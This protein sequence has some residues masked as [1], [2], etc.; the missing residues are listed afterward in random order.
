[1]IDYS[2]SLE[3]LHS[4]QRPDGGFSYQPGGQA[5]P[6]CTAW[7]IL[8]LSAC[9]GQDRSIHLGRDYL[10][11]LQSSDG[12]V[13]LSSQHPEACW[14]TALAVLAWDQAP[15]FQEAKNRAIDFLVGFTGQHFPKPPNSVSG[16]D[17][18]IR[19]WPWIAETHSWVVPTSLAILALQS[20]G[21]GTHGRVK[22][23]IRMI[24]DR[25][26][27][28][29]G[30]NY[31]SP[32]AFGKALHPLPEATGVA[33]QALAGKVEREGIASSIQYLSQETTR[34]HTPVSLGWG[35]LG[36]GAWGIIPQDKEEMIRTSLALQQKYGPYPLP[37]LAL[38]LYAAHRAGGVFPLPMGDHASRSAKAD[39][40]TSQEVG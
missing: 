36:L 7:A 6:D 24:L 14:P 30:W 22:E 4:H 1:M 21:L 12:R 23:G 37:S 20:V 11:K 33:L 18:A 27:A 29:G 35:L 32:S 26:L 9:E 28:Q 38:L 25:Q 2:P 13:P 17:P 5:R 31:G 19:G 3:F 10:K 40:Q 34:L 39:H 8:T 15:E 16:H